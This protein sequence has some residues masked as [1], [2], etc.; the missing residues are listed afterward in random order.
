MSKK[1]TTHEDQPISPA[2]AKP[3]SKSRHKDRTSISIKGELYARLAEAARRN[4]RPIQWEARLA[5]ERHL[6][7]QESEQ[8]QSESP[9]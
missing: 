8:R 5:I 3:R 6:E 7:Q 4:C 1:K 2:A 9:D